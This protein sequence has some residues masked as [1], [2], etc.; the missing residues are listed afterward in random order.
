M[1]EKT[2]RNM[3]M[4]VVAIVL[5]GFALY[6][7]RPVMVFVAVSAFLAI[8]LHPLEV[9][10]ERLMPKWLSLLA[11][12][13][14]I[15]GILTGVGAAFFAQAKSVAEKAPVYAERFQEMG[16][17]LLEALQSIGIE[18]TWEEVGT[19]EAVREVISFATSSIQSVIVLAGQMLLLAIMVVFM[20][21]EAPIY[22]KKL[23][24]SLRPDQS[25]KIL[26]SLDRATY[27]FQRYVVTKTLV[28][29]STGLLTGVICALLG[30]DFPFVWGALAFQLNFIPYLGS[31][32]A[33][34][35]PTLVAFLQFDDPAMGVACFALLGSLQFTIG[36]V[37]EPR[38]MGRTLELS[39]LVVF[40]SMIFWGWF[41]GLWGVVLAVPLTASVKVICE[42]VDSFKPFAALLG[43]EAPEQEQ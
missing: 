6:F 37:I 25:K 14:G 40:F 4:V 38:I 2:H 8:L 20:L 1:S 28:S 17:W 43:K 36:N 5:V 15:G 26:G 12:C 27:K 10:L 35:P 42:H 9:W 41:W 13:L 21:V 7:T 18:L 31:I 34:F 32:V 3:P 33:V 16:Q 24:R 22:R 30:L 19:T 11:I 29:L 23:A 39:P